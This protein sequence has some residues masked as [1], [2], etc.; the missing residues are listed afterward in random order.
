MRVVCGRGRRWW[1]WGG[2]EGTLLPC[3][4]LLRP[5][6]CS[7]GSHTAAAR[8]PPGA[9][10]PAPRSVQNPPAPHVRSQLA[11]KSAAARGGGF[12]T[13]PGLVIPFGT[14]ELALGGL[15]PAGQARFRELLAAAERAP[16][17]ELDAVCDELQA[18]VR[19]LRVPDAVLRGVCGAFPPGTPLMC[20]SS[21]NV[22]DLAGMS[23]AGLYDSIPNVPSDA[24]ADVAAAVTAVWASLHTRRAV[25]SRRAAGVPQGD[26][27]MAVLVQAML[28]PALSFVL[29]TA[30]P[31]GD[32]PGRA[33]AE[34]AVGLGETLA[35]GARGSAWRLSVDKASGDTQTLAFANFAQALLPAAAVTA[36]AGVGVGVGGAGSGGGSGGAAAGVLH[37]CD[38]RVLDYSQMAL[39]RSGEAR[40]RLGEKLGGVAGFLEDAFGGPQ[41]VEGCLIGDAVYVVQ[42][43]PQPM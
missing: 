19:G 6:S 5:Y 2:E 17:A 33:V 42:T 38:V 37:A 32:D 41:D 18:L 25:L 4:T 13:P 8:G 30:S 20:R 36:A 3:T 1:G 16:V 35:S 31:L 11:A 26:A 23:G 28:S 10:L 43:R 24:P 27:C 12:R 21:A 15:P 22:E 29:H 7:K 34:V 14:M 9:R 39:S 40:S